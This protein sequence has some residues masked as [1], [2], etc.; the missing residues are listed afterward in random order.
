M[1]SRY[2][3][4]GE[5]F[6]AEIP[7]CTDERFMAEIVDPA[8]VRAEAFA[9]GREGDC[10]RAKCGDKASYLRGIRFRLREASNKTIVRAAKDVRRVPAALI[11]NRI[12]SDAR[13]TGWS[14]SRATP[15][16]R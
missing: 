12:A 8:S 2:F 15:A 3:R 11:A 14:H 13:A 16:K 9:V 1:A 10:R 7:K 5:F 4:L 6:R